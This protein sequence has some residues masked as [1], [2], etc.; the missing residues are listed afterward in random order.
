MILAGNF[1][2]AVLDF[3]T[4]EGWN[5]VL[6]LSI[7]VIAFVG[8]KIIASILTKILYRS[9]VDG[10]AIA[11]Y[12][13][14]LKVILWILTV[15]AVASVLSIPTSSLVVGLSS[16]ALAI[17]LALKDSLANLANGILI[18]YNK[19]FRRGDYIEIDGI[20]G[21]IKNIKLL[22]TELLTYDNRRIVLPNSKVVGGTII[23]NTAM[24]TRRITFNFAVSYD[25]NPSLVEKVLREAFEKN[26]LVNKNPKVYVFLSAHGTSSL[27]FTVRCWTDTEDYWD[28]YN[29]MPRKVYDAFIRNDIVVPYNQLD[30]YLKPHSRLDIEYLNEEKSAYKPEN[31]GNPILDASETN[32]GNKH[33]NH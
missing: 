30:V 14:V 7:I 29:G 6:V 4:N 23:N 25:S 26:H 2:D 8:I 18:I 9:K 32:G 16:V 12:V 15:F 11:F 19:P 13:A 10:S 20:D 1:W 5:I 22:T 3:L 31:T 27:T 28:V 33:E 17:A 21:V 24:P